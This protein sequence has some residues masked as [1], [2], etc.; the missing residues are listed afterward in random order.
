MAD[1]GH[2]G[3]LPMPPKAPSTPGATGVARGTPVLPGAAIAAGR[4]FAA[5]DFAS[6]LARLVALLSAGHAQASPP[7]G[8]TDGGLDAADE[9][10]APS[11][12]GDAVDVLRAEVAL[13]VA[14]P[15]PPV[16]AVPV[17]PE[18][19]RATPSST[20]PNPDGAPTSGSTTGSDGRAPARSLSV[21]L[22][23]PGAT[24]AAEHRSPRAPEAHAMPTL[25]LLPAAAAGAAAFTL[26]PGVPSDPDAAATAPAPS[27]AEAG[28]A[29][30]A[31]AVAAP[32][33]D[34]LARP[35]SAAPVIVAATVVDTM[36]PQASRQIA[37]TVTWHVPA[38][39]A[40][41][42]QIRLNPE[43]LGPLEVQ[44][45]L[46]GDKVSVRFEL[47]DERV[48]DVVQSSLPSLSSM[49]SA[50]GL[51]LDDAQVFAQA[52]GQGAFQHPASSNAP[53]SSNR[54][55][56]DEAGADLAARAA[57]RPPIRR[58]LLDD[59]A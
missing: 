45:R 4:P 48:R 10:V 49:L 7:L 39:G 41:E 13:A 40:A 20:D 19:P 34:T 23:P 37:E 43:E 26:A 30:P 56:G 14:D 21:L 47:A 9:P 25:P 22:T 55:D 58:G 8:K 29:S 2:V 59:Y 44:L 31:V 38:Q 18:A 57:V 15:V 27:L 50:R 28:P 17:P 32:P 51:Q 36:H 11:D 33:L 5:P 3:G 42:V 35:A 54:K 52:R 16:I 46:D 6:D 24:V 1:L 12:A 53:W